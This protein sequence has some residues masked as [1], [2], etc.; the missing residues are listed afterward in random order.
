M[1]ALRIARALVLAGLA[2]CIL[3][4]D[5][6]LRVHA[7]APAAQGDA[8]RETSGETSRISV[9]DR[10]AWTLRN[11]EQEPLDAV[12]QA[13]GCSLA[14]AKRRIASAQAV[15]ERRLGHA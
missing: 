2:G 7:S 11:V 9:E 1:P 5:D 12:A 3:S 10:L 8:G 13:C 14:T 4:E 6:I 15:L